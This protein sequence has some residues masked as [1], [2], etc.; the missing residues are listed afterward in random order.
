MTQIFIFTFTSVS[1]ITL[2]LLQTQGMYTIYIYIYTT[3]PF[4]MVIRALRRRLA[5]ACV[6]RRLPSQ[7]K[8]GIVFRG[9][10]SCVRVDPL[11]ITRPLTS[12]PPPHTHTQIR[13]HTDI[14]THTHPTYHPNI[15]LHYNYHYISFK[16][17]K[18]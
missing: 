18:K 9:S 16:N 2:R 12:P 7:P 13:P 10:Y 8:Q 14:H 6:P 1:I 15:N 17:L 4:L 11:P 5:R 3:T